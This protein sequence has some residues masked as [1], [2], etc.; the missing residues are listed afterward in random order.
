[1]MPESLSKIADD[2]EKGQSWLCMRSVE[3]LGG[4]KFGCMFQF[5]LVGEGVVDSLVMIGV[6]CL[7]SQLWLGEGLGHW[8][9]CRELITIVQ[10]E[11]A[12]LRTPLGFQVIHG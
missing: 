1:M 3:R 2:F 5:K 8:H 7:D 12:G 4:E 10:V 11:M 6:R 9:L